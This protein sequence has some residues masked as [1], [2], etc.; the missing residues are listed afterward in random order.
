MLMLKG[1]NGKS[2][3]AN[4][5]LNETYSKCFVYNDCPVRSIGG[6]YLDSTKY[7]LE[8]L[9]ECITHWNENEVYPDEIYEYLIVYT[10]HTEESLT[11]FIDWLNKNKNWISCKDIILTCR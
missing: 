3:I 6:I 2:P 7:S 5:I 8:D 11:N 4:I 9:K 10:N 1:N